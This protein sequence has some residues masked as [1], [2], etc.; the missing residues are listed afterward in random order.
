MS[1]ALSLELVDPEAA[2]QQAQDGDRTSTRSELFKKAVLGGGTFV[3]GGVLIGGLPKVALAAPSARQDVEILNFALTLEFLEAEFYTQAVANGALS[4]ELL[5]FATVVR[6]HE[7]AHVEFL[8]N[9]LGSAAV[10]KPTFDFG[11]T[12]TDA[13]AFT[14][15]AVVLEDTGV[16]AYNGQGPRLRRRLVGAA[17]SIVSVEARHAAWIRRIAFGP[18]FAERPD[19]F[20]APVAFDPA[21]SMRRILRAVEA[22]GFIKG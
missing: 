15:T 13:A 17:G 6:D 1:G 19:S 10:A 21:A 9:A 4:G 12:V 20:P 18:D 14:A 7:V 16:A 5:S 11:S 8:Q 3:A 2:L 22:T